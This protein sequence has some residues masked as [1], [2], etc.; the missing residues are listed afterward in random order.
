[1][2]AVKDNQENLHQERT[3]ETRYFISS[4]PQLLKAVRDHWGI[5]NGLHWKLDVTF[6]EDEPRV[7]KG[8]GPQNFAI[9]RHIALNLLNQ[10]KTAR[11]GL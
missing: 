4:L 11:C 3:F 8:N 7:R 2:L 1:M 9:L 10:E 6:R 5:E